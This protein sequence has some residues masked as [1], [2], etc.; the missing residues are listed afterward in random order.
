MIKNVLAGILCFVLITYLADAVRP[1]AT[2]AMASI[3][4]AILKSGELFVAV[5]WDH[6]SDA[7]KMG[8]YISMLVNGTIGSLVGAMFGLMARARRMEA[9]QK[10]QSSA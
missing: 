9:A 6:S 3:L 1:D 2:G 8:L 5:I 10:N 7:P 4:D